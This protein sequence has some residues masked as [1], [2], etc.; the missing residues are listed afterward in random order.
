MKKR[1]FI[2]KTI[3]VS[4]IVMLAFASYYE[5]TSDSPVIEIDLDDFYRETDTDKAGFPT[6]GSGLQMRSNC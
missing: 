6:A 3:D 1:D 2:G 4:K 5:K